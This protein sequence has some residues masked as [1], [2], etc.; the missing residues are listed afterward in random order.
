MSRTLQLLFR[1][2][3]RAL[4]LPQ[5][6]ETSNP[7]SSWHDQF[8]SKHMG[9]HQNPCF[10][11]SSKSHIN[12]RC[13]ASCS[14]GPEISF[15][16]WVHDSNRCAGGAPKLV[17]SN[18]EPGRT[19]RLAP[20]GKILELDMH[21]KRCRGLGAARKTAYFTIDNPCS[22]TPALRRRILVRREQ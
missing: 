9:M 15:H 12:F 16:Q 4:Q 10:L 8:Q 20:L 3:S 19:R 11:S 1:D 21:L 2:S 18:S 22:S 6:S 13:A 5:L 7:H 14:S 17:V